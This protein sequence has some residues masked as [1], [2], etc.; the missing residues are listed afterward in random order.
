MTLGLLTK[1]CCRHL[2]DANAFDVVHAVFVGTSG[3]TSGGTSASGTGS[4]PGFNPAAANPAG[5]NPADSYSDSVGSIHYNR[6]IVCSTVEIPES[7]TE[8]VAPDSKSGSIVQNN[9]SV[10]N[11]NSAQRN[12]IIVHKLILIT[13]LYQTII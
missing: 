2:N 12:K 7:S 6:K 1:Q 10:Q 13:I 8:V 3:A 4:N 5:A 11:N 9:R